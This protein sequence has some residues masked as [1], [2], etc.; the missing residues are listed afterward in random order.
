MLDTKNVWFDQS[1]MIPVS[2]FNYRLTSYCALYQLL[3]HATIS[4]LLLMPNA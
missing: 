1:T 2:E 4:P 3:V